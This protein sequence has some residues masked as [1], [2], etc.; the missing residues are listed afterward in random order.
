MIYRVITSIDDRCLL[1]VERFQIVSDYLQ[2]SKIT[3][4]LNA[5]IPLETKRKLNIHGRSENVRSIP[6]PP[7][8]VRKPLLF[9][10]F[11]EI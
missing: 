5:L 7:E 6:I 4:F 9:Q 3:I 11:Q 1:T 10:C 2:N 8:N